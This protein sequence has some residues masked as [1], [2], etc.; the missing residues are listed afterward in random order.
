MISAPGVGSGLDVN[1]IVQ[2]LMEIE[3]QPLSRLEADKQGLET[4]LSAYGK[5]KSSLSTFQS[6]FADLKTLDAFEVYK[7]VSSD[8]TAFTASANS[9][10]AV[11][12]N[13]IEVIRLAE[14][15]KMGSVS[16]ADTDTTLLGGSGDQ[17]TATING[18][19]FSVDIGGK[20]LSQIR[21]AIN[22]APDNTGV[23]ATI[24]SENSGSHRLVLTATATGNDNALNL[25]FTGTVGTALGLTDINNRAQLDSELQIDGLYTVTR[26]GNTIDDAIGGITLNLL[27][28][29]TSP[30]QLTV[31]RDV[32]K[33]KE[34]VQGFVDA[35][36]ELKSTFDGLSGQGNDLEADNTLRSIR[37]Q[38]QGV[39]NTP[40]AG[41]TTGLTYLSEIGVT[42]QRDGTLALDSN[43][44]ESAVNSDFSGV[45]ELFAND[46]QGYLFRL[47]NLIDGFVQA[48]GLINIREDGLNTR[49][50]TTEQRISDMEYRLQLREQRLNDQFSRLD[51]LMGQLNGTSQFLTKQLAAL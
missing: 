18:N 11:S 31:S 33:V 51:E 27:A 21:D 3:R 19:A 45:A 37:S 15:H 9:S 13:S 8:E 47:G 40:P 12:F 34:T 5:L 29:T 32:D 35:Y 20:T 26:S 43:D 25:S 30:I 16:I 38:I 42:F 22:D 2:Q 46:D 7:G 14:A 28:E 39:F 10:A 49:I 50:D 23:S 6:A 24:I 41:L 1:S 48:D 36:N 44:L 17:L 4:Q